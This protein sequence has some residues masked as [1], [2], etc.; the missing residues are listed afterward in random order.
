M[1]FFCHEKRSASML[2]LQN[3]CSTSALWEVVAPHQRDL[4]LLEVA[5]WDTFVFKTL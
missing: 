1:D 4:V 2:S 3:K 5:A